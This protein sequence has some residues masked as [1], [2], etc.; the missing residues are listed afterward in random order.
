MVTA[1]KVK[2]KLTV[3]RRLAAARNLEARHPVETREE[4]R[5]SGQRQPGFALLAGQESPPAAAS[6]WHTACFERECKLSR[7]ETTIAM[8]AGGAAAVTAQG[9]RPCAAQGSR[10]RFLR[11]ECPSPKFQE[12][13]GQP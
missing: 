12:V 3:L 8:C 5:Y 6:A 11:P 7:E 1:P 10:H 13:G 4:L 9:K 2:V